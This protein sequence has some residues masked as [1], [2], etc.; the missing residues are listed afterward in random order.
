MA[1]HG[2]QQHSKVANQLNP[3]RADCDHEQAGPPVSARC[4]GGSPGCSAWLLE[5]AWHL[6]AHAAQCTP[7]HHLQNRSD[8]QGEN[9]QLELN[10]YEAAKTSAGA[11]NHRIRSRMAWLVTSLGPAPYYTFCCLTL[12]AYTLSSL[13]HWF[14]VACH[15][16]MALPACTHPCLQPALPIC[17]HPAT[18]V[19]TSS[20]GGNAKPLGGGK[21]SGAAAWSLRSAAG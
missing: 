2:K 14:G 6:H 4:G 17:T 16:S 8:R 20:S 15:F 7:I 10:N 5:H 19:Y 1:P 18:C 9:T 13:Q 3:R 12:C 21:G 11:G